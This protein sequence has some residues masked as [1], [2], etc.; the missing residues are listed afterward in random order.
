VI[1]PGVKGGV[2]GDHPS[3][4][5]LTSGDLRF[6][7]DFRS[8]YAGLLQDWLEGSPKDVLGDYAPLALVRAAAPSYGP[9]APPPA[10]QTRTFV[11]VGSR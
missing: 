10:G 5:S 8:V 1:G 7:V 9:L 3:L 2:V 4:T 11:P 6:G